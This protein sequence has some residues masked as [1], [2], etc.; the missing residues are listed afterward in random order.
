MHTFVV[1]VEGGEKAALSLSLSVFCWR[2][3]IKF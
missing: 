1:F 3:V 2:N